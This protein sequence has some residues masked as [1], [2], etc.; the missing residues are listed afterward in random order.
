MSNTGTGVLE[1]QETQE[2]IREPK[3]F[4]V[5]FHNDE[6]TTFDFVILALTQIFHHEVEA[7]FELT[8]KIHMMGA[9]VVGVYPEEIAEMKTLE[10]LAL[11]KEHGFPLKVTFEEF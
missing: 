3:K 8:Q 4:K 5:I 9:A 11:A 6:K 2:D 10:T 7:A 1:R